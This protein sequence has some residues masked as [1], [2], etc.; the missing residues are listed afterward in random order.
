[1]KYL[2]IIVGLISF[3]NSLHGQTVSSE[4]VVKTLKLTTEQKASSIKLSVI[5]D[6]E[7]RYRISI[8][9]HND[10]QHIIVLEED[11]PQMKQYLEDVI[12]KYKNWSVIARQ[13]N[14]T[15][16]SKRLELGSPRFIATSNIGNKFCR[17]ENPSLSCTFTVEKN[18]CFLVFF[19]WVGNA[20]NGENADIIEFIVSNEQELKNLISVFDV[21]KLRQTASELVK[22]H[23]A[24]H[25]ESNRINSLFK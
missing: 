25:N 15:E 22:K 18:K 1:M 4:K 14:V 12:L 11:V 6:F 19:V 9:L 10:E 2:I 7:K 16:F 3:L 20:F 8:P 13:N 21:V 24:T 5:P 23:Q 17:Q